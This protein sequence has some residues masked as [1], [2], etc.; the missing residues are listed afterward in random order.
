MKI[1]AYV[2]RGLPSEAVE[3]RAAEFRAAGHLYLYR[4]AARFGVV[5]SCDAIEAEDEAIVAAYRAVGIGAPGESVPAPS[6]ALE[7]LMQLETDPEVAPDP[8]SPP[9]DF[10]V[11]SLA[12]EDA[13][14][15]AYLE[16]LEGEKRDAFFEAQGDEALAAFLVDRAGKVRK[17][18]WTT[19]AMGNMI[20]RH[21]GL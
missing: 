12:L 3:A 11:P 9:A 5:E 18:G 20:E 21:L 2:A 7:P 15:K 1:L 14:L 4:D 6:P 19:G 10:A 8:P 16:G 17:D 13:L